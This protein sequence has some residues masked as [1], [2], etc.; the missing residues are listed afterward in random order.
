MNKTERIVGFKLVN[1]PS[2]EQYVV[3][4]ASGAVVFVPKARFDSSASTITYLPMKAGDL[5]VDRKTSEER[6]R[7]KD[8]NNFVCQ[9]KLNSIDLAEYVISRGEKVIINA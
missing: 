1:T 7:L 9:G 4:T 3:T 2:G 6:K 8:G 5:Y